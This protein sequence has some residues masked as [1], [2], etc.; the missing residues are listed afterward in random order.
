MRHGMKHAH[1]GPVLVTQ[2]KIRD[3]GREFH[4]GGGGGGEPADKV[5]PLWDGLG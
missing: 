3:G 1:T 5:V 2:N 4:S